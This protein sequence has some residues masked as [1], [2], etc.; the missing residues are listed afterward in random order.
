MHP[1]KRC[2]ATQHLHTQSVTTRRR[3]GRNGKHEAP[4]EL[5]GASASASLPITWKA[6]RLGQERGV[7]G[8]GRGQYRCYVAGLLMTG[9]LWAHPCIHA[10][11]VLTYLTRL[12]A[13]LRVGLLGLFTCVYCVGGWFGFVGFKLLLAD[14]LCWVEHIF[15]SW[16]LLALLYLLRVTQ[17]KHA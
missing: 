15:G 5:S 10:S 16:V 2:V 13:E 14:V 4:R 3:C 8:V 7:S 17:R 1:V 11:C 12:G 6:K 9:C